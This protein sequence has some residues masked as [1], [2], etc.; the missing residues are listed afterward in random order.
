MPCANEVLRLDPNNKI[1]L[2]RRAKAISRPV[3]ASVED[4]R[5]AIKD[6]EKMNSQEERI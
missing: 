6:L 1:A 4:Y 2:Y 5:Q 3:N